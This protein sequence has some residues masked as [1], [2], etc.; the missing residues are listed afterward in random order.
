FLILFN[1]YAALKLK[2]DQKIPAVPLTLAA[3]SVG[4]L[5]ITNIV[6]VY[7]PLLF[8]KDILWNWRKI[9]S[10][11]LRIF[12][13]AAVCLLLFLYR[14]DFKFLSFL[15]KSGEQFE[16]FSKPKVIPVWDMVSSWFL[17]GNMLFA[18]V[19]IRDYHNR[20]GFEYKA[21]FMEVY[22]SWVPYLFV[23]AVV[24]LIFWSY[25][26]NFKNR[27]VQIL[28]LSFLVDIAIHVIF[29]FGLHTSYIY[30]GHFVFVFPLMLGWLFYAYR[31]A[32]K[33]LSV[34]Y[35]SILVL[36]FYLLLNNIFRISEFFTFLE[37]YYR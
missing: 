4:G 5:T 8:E 30:G 28:M 16:K 23:L 15:N 19:E 31:N 14:V 25:V 3:I 18:G 21:L 26:K 33:T 6:K 12:A 7:I 2:K 20:K 34:L 36:F 11:M 13:T 10:S 1:Y 37:A 29:R 32:A 27:F 35:Y 22:N 9:W 17:G 24:L